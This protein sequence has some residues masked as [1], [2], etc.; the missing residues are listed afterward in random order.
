MSH[1]ITR[2]RALQ[3]AGA[4]SLALAAPAAL[5][6]DAPKA[7]KVLRVAFNSAE[8]GFDPAKISDLYSRT[9]TPHIFEALYA[10]DHLARPFRI[11]PLTADGMPETSADF[12][13]WTI[14]VRPGIFYTDDP[15]FKGQRRELVAADYVYAIKR[16]MDPANKSP[17]GSVIQDLGIAGLNE[18]RDEAVA[19]KI[20]FDYDR[21]LSGVRALDR[22][23]LKLTL[24][25]PR[26]R[27]LRRRSR[28]RTRQPMPR[29]H[30][31]RI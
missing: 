27:L 12:R 3:G 14:R 1:D 15:A 31:H 29:R 2:R 8:T 17:L 7:L 9:I 21:E 16:L 20:A 22:H 23:T 13:E 6:A 30:H 24:D 28:Q 11:K 5:A 4:L 25:Q 10:Y 18:L 19:K 26:P